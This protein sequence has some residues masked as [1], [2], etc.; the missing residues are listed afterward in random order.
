MKLQDHHLTNSFLDVC[1]TAPIH[2]NVLLIL[3]EY[4]FL[5]YQH[6]KRF[7]FFFLKNLLLHTTQFRTVP[8][9]IMSSTFSKLGA[10][11]FCLSARSFVR[12][13]FLCIA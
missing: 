5:F 7:F 13:A 8:F 4:F 6:R 2:L 11:C 12:H 9:L 1:K 3:N 10:Y